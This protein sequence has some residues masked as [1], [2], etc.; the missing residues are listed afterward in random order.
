MATKS[1]QGITHTTTSSVWTLLPLLVGL[2]YTAFL[3]T[4]FGRS[5]DAWQAVPVYLFFCLVLLTLQE[6]VST[7]RSFSRFVYVLGTS[8]FA[9]AYAG[10][11]VFPIHKLDFTRNPATYVLGEAALLVAFAMDMGGRSRQRAQ[12]RKGSSATAEQNAIERFGAMATDFAGL[13]V[14]FLGSAFLLDLLGGQTVPH[15][16]GVHLGPPYVVVN[17]DSM[18]HLHWSSPINLLDGLDLV[19]G[20]AA[21]GVALMLL[22]MAGVLLPSADDVNR[23]TVQ[24]S[25]GQTVRD[26]LV[27]VIGSLRLVLSPLVWLVPAFALAKFA[28]QTAQYFNL[29]ASAKSRIIDLFNPFSPTGISYWRSGIGALLLGLVAVAAMVVAVLVIEQEPAVVHRT[30]HTFRLAGRAIALTWAFFMYSMALLNA[31]VVLLGVTKVEPFQVGAPGLIALLVGM[32]M[33]MNE[34]RHVSHAPASQPAPTAILSSLP[35]LRSDR[36]RQPAHR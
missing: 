11:F 5:L 7:D 14:F 28:Q 15:A 30:R 2:A 23:A 3:L 27:Q 26:T 12:T 8:A 4:G 34:S 35:Q 21:A 19:L 24:R 31:V 25:F 33:L 9:V 29:A 36:A 1:G 13:A 16:I 22:V 20:L 32:L 17:L 6:I 10:E 18:F